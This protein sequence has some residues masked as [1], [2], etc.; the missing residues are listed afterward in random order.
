MLRL[1]TTFPAV[2]T[3]LL[4]GSGYAGTILVA[5]LTN[6]QES[7]PTNPTTS[8][9]VPRTSFGTASFFL[10]DAMTS[11]T[12]TATV[13]GIDFTGSQSADLNDNL[14]AAHIHAGSTPTPTWP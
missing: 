12:F 11:M 13:F 1:Q 3:L 10:N 5:N 8:T 2:F 4:A 9:G 14:T 7:P 6:S